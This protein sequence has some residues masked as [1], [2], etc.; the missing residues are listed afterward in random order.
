MLQYTV[1]VTYIIFMF[2][3][4]RFSR[5][6]I[7]DKDKR[8]QCRFCRLNKCFRAGMKKEG[9]ET[10]D[11]YGHDCI[12]PFWTTLKVFWQTWP[13]GHGVF[14][15]SWFFPLPRQGIDLSS[16][17][18]GKRYRQR[19]CKR[20]QDGWNWLSHKISDYLVCVCI[21]EGYNLGTK[22]YDT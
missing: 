6:C 17:T 11:L 21:Y 13:D 12:L 16:G 3:T 20:L 9:L 2:V 7:V 10:N 8:N 15:S 22:F 1:T 14:A 4:C 18:E 19:I 5:Q